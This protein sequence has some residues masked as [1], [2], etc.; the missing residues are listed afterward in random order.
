MAQSVLHKGAAGVRWG[1][2]KFHKMADSFSLYTF[3]LPT[4][5]DMFPFVWVRKCLTR[6][7]A[8]L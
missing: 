4:F 3:V 2:R 7:H 6:L 5:W 8:L 1:E